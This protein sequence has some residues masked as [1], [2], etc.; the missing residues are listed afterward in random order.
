MLTQRRNLMLENSPQ[1]KL[2]EKVVDFKNLV[3]PLYQAS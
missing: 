1:L 3:F 2:I